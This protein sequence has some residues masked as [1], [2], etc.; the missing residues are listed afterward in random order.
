MAPRQCDRFW[1]LDLTAAALV[2]DPQLSK[3]SKRVS[4][5][6]EGRWI[7]KTGID[8]GAPTPILTAAL[9]AIQLARGCEISNQLF[10]AMRY[11]FGGHREKTVEG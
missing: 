7:V 1:L 5:S 2:E 8:E 4:D 10:L 9:R 6:D 11:E 3:S